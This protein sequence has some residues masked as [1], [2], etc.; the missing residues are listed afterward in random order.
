[1]TEVWFDRRD[2]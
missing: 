2:I 1:V